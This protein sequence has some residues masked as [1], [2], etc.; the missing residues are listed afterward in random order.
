MDDAIAKK[1]AE[2]VADSGN[3]SHA[4]DD[5]WYLRWRERV[6][7]Y[8]GEV[9]GSDVAKEFRKLAGTDVFGPS[10]AV[11]YLEALETKLHS[12]ASASSDDGDRPEMRHT[13]GP[14]PANRELS[15]RRVFIVHG[16]DD[17]AKEALARF[18][19]KIGLEP[20]IL[21]EQPNLGRTVIEKFEVFSAVRFAVVLLT[22]DDIASAAN[23]KNQ[24]TK[25]A[26]QNVVLELGYFLGKLGRQRVCPLYVDGVELPS[27]YDGV[28][29]VKFDKDGAWRTKVAQELV[30]AGL[31]IDLQGLL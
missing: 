15:E 31:S 26:R 12:H 25:R 17:A 27:D 18:I 6:A 14:R 4:S 24:K 28:V 23:D 16:H 19:T 9:L 7:V 20:I 10:Q 30:H 2:F 21:H 1:L 8:I 11:G 13:T 5:Y 3:A 29:Y 22:P